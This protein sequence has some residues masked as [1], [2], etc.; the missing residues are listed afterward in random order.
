[1]SAA[2]EFMRK[3]DE[4]GRYRDHDGVLDV[5]FMTS[6][7][8]RYPGKLH[9]NNGLCIRAEMQGASPWAYPDNS[10]LNEIQFTLYFEG[11][12]PHSI[13]VDQG[14]I[15][16]HHD[17]PERATKQGF[18][19]NFRIARNLFVHGR[20]EAGSPAGNIVTT[21]GTLARAAIWLTPKSVNGFNAD[22]FRELSL[23]RQVELQTAV[24]SF[25]EVANQVPANQAATPEQYGNARVAF[26]RI[27][28]ILQP[29]IPMPDEAKTVERAIRGVAFPLWVLNWDY[30]LGSDE[31]GGP[32]VWVN[33]FVEEGAPRSEFGR[34]ALRIIPKIRQALSAEGVNRWPYV[35]LRTAT[36]HKLA[37]PH[38]TAR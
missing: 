38:A 3:F 8:K 16:H 27:L 35:R 13:L 14:R 18:L 32:A 29:Y 33:V 17:V 19:D 20:P 23:D 34:F 31:E 26:M 22:H 15:V 10:P 24:Q 9:F 6:G 30:E 37:R 1:M 36:E 11:E 7:G 21:A 2:D 4:D 12:T 25:L 5:V 28:E